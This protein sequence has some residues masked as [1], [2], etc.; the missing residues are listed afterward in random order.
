MATELTETNLPSDLDSSE[1]VFDAVDLVS[2]KPSSVPLIFE[3]IME[4]APTSPKEI[5]DSVAISKSVTFSCL[6]KLLSLGLVNRPSRGEYE[7]DDITLHPDIV[8]VIG[9]LR[10]RKQLE[11]CR[12]AARVDAF[13]T[14][15]LTNEIGGHRS[16]LRATAI[17]LSEKGFLNQKRKPFEKSPKSYRIT[18]PAK[19]GLAVL[20]VEEYLGMDGRHVSPYPNG[21]EGTDF[22]TA[23]EIEDAHYIDQAN[24][25]WVR[26][27]EIADSLDKNQKKTLMR[28]ADMVDR[29]LLAS[30]PRREKKVFE[31]TDKTIEMVRDLRLFRI[32]KAQQLDLYTLATQADSNESFTPDEL[33]ETLVGMGQSLTPQTLNTAIEELKRSELIEGNSRTGYRFAPP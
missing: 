31:A 19:R 3:H 6:D 8:H 32:S 27:D 2:K 20:D 13:E 14:S 26:P 1:T 15:D 12:F 4:E 21:I 33:Y 16:A 7:P 18:E 11:L 30:K 10:S 5:Q 22:R 17:Q 29:G 25:R 23:Y 28:L 24:H 9:E